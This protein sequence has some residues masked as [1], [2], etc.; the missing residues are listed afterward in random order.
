MVETLRC[1]CMER[2]FD[3]WS[4]AGVAH[5]SQT[6]KEKKNLKDRKTYTVKSDFLTSIFLLVFGL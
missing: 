4:G 2:G 1:Q 5:A 6:K 3:P